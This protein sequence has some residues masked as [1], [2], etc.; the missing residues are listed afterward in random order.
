MEGHRGSVGR[1]E[2]GITEVTTWLIGVISI[3][4][5]ATDPSSR[6]DFENQLKDRFRDE[7]LGIGK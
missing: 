3:T 4:I 2:M 6:D 5:K 7:G 1:E